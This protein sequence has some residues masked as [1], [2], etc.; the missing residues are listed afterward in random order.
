MGVREAIN[1]KRGLSLFIAAAVIA[2]GLGMV[3]WNLNG[4]SSGALGSGK[5]Y[6][7]LDD[8]KSFQ[9]DA[10]KQM[11]PFTVDG[12]T[13]YR[14][15]VYTC[16]GGKSK[17]VGYIQRYTPHGKKIAEKMLEQQRASS[18]MPQ[19]NPELLEN[20]EIKRPNDPQWV[21]QSNVA[22]AGQIADVKCP[23]NANETPE[24]VIP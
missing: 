6:I 5:D 2:A 23:H 4:D 14:A 16:D 1:Q 12:K 7:T 19:L 10:S 18:G 8:G 21:R 11:P 20:T 15:F 24:L 13:A 22:L 3:Y 9:L 17:W